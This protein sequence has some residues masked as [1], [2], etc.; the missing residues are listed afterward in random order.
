MNTNIKYI[1]MILNFT[2]SFIYS[3]AK[4]IEMRMI[5]EKLT[6]PP[7]FMTVLNVTAATALIV[8][9]D[10]ENDNQR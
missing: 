2:I 9:S 6:M 8:C 10:L 1:A 5:V 7:Y 4:D 3:A